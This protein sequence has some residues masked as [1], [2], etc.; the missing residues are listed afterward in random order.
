MGRVFGLLQDSARRT[1]EKNQRTRGRIGYFERCRGGG[2]GTLDKDL[3]TMIGSE[4]LLMEELHM[5]RRKH[6]A[7]L[8]QL[9]YARPAGDAPRFFKTAVHSSPSLSGLA[10]QTV[11]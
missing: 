10:F 8:L 5:Q 11:S 2:A 7:L 9:E 1:R 6:Q 3:L 4:H